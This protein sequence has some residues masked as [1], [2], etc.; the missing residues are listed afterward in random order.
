MGIV[1]TLIKQAED[2]GYKGANANA[3]VCQDIVLS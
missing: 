3:K 1:S 2:A